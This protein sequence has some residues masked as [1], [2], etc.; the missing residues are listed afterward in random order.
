[1]ATRTFIV[2]AEAGADG[3]S[4]IRLAA[5][6][7]REFEAVLVGVAAQDIVPPVTATAAGA[8]IVTAL[9][10]AQEKT[11]EANLSAAEKTFRSVAAS[12][13]CGTEWRQSIATPADA[14]ARGARSADLI[15]VGRKPEELGAGRSRSLDPA[16]VLMRAGRPVLLAPPGIDHLNLASVLV[17]W[18]DTRESRRAVIDSIPLLCRAER[19][20][21]VAVSRDSGEQDGAQSAVH[22]V[23]AYLVRH[24]IPASAQVRALR[25]PTVPAELLLAAEQHEAGLIVAGGYGHG[26]IQEL[27]LG[28]VT[29]TLLRHYPK[30][31]L[32]S[33]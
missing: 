28:G 6:L 31:C 25:E 18:K 1:M 22:D 15:I 24:G 13:G 19:V 7:A 4:R 20:A 9:L 26:R 17:A 14:L 5:R 32:L 29:R 27:V 8:V 3:Q 10:A 23:A 11:I 16:D 2:H 30:C 33:H 21:V 12:E